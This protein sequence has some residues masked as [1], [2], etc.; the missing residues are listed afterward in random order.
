MRFLL[1]ENVDPQ[2]AE[3]LRALRH[4]ADHI[5]SLGASGATDQEVARLA[6]GYDVRVTMDLHR[7]Q[8]EWVNIYEGLLSSIRII[9][10]R[11]SGQSPTDLMAQLRT[12]VWK[13]SEWE[14]AF[15]D[16]EARLIT[17]GSA[18]ASVRMM[19]ADQIAELLEERS[20]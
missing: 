19:T 6:S 14:Q 10:L 15:A 8:A 4:D 12:L 7:Q 3:V 1:D 11:F 20:T 5:Q 17:L 16:L 18:G 9:R 2:L 13:W